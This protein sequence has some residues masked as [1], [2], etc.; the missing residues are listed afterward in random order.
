MGV[1]EKLEA[2]VRERDALLISVVDLLKTDRRIVA[3]W[4]GG[5]LGRGTADNL[6]DIDIYVV[7]AQHYA[8]FVY[9][10]TREFVS[11][12]PGLL[13]TEVAPR[14]APADGAYLLTMFHGD[15]GPHQVDWYWITDR[16][17]AV[18]ANTR[19]L[20]NYCGHP[21]SIDINGASGCYCGEWL[22][23]P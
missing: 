4:L 1:A 11:R 23:G 12:V 18:P 20:F 3:A 9:G 8:R 19:V 6:S 22:T 14:N 21:G 17:E 15:T 10:A 2:R 5:S 7:V 13:L 16:I